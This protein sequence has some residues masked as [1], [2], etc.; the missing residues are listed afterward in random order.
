[1]TRKHDTFEEAL[2]SLI[3]EDGPGGTIEAPMKYYMN[4]KLY[5]CPYCKDTGWLPRFG[6]TP[7]HC[8]CKAPR[9]GA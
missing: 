2:R 7:V 9:Y 5:L 1:M 8:R 3:D 4:G 6:G